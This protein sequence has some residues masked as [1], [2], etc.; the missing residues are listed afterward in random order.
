MQCSATRA[1]EGPLKLSDKRRFLRRKEWKLLLLHIQTGDKLAKP[2]FFVA[3]SW[4]SRHC[5]NLAEGG[6]LLLRFHLTFCRYFLGHVV[7]RN[8]L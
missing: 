6:G 5:R 2:Q 8:L 1:Q 3:Y 7:C 4:L